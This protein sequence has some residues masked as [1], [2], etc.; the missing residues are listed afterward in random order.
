MGHETICDEEF[1]EV[2]TLDVQDDGALATSMQFD[3]P[4]IV[5]ISPGQMTLDGNGF[6]SVHSIINNLGY[7]CTFEITGNAEAALA[8]AVI[9]HLGEEQLASIKLT[10]INPDK[11]EV[12]EQLRPEK[13]MAQYN[14][15]VDANGPLNNNVVYIFADKIIEIAQRDAEKNPCL[16]AH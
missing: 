11:F 8:E 1:N 2:I 4:R 6:N 10:A 5:E 14:S 3:H 7:K 13:Y 9:I 12:L 16:K 15:C